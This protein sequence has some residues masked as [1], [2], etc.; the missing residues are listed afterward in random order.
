MKSFALNQQNSTFSIM[1]EEEIMS[2]EILKVILKGNSTEDTLLLNITDENG[3]LLYSKPL[4]PK[5]AEDFAVQFKEY[6]EVAIN[7]RFIFSKQLQV[8]IV[9]QDGSNYLVE[10]QYV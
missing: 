6:P 8:E 4:I 7:K 2:A 9:A 5:P 1:G 10:V 3:F